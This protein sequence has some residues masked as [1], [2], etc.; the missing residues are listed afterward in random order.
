MPLKTPLP[1]LTETPIIFIVHCLIS[2]G[3]T[4]HILRRKSNVRSAMGWIAL[5]WLTL[6]TGPLLYIVFGINRISR[7]AAR[8]AQIAPTTEGRR[9]VTALLEAPAPIQT[10]ATIAGQITGMPLTAGNRITVYH[11][12]RAAYG[13]MIG[14]IEQAQHSVALA[15]YIFRNDAVGRRFIAAL[16]RAHQRGVAVRVLIDGVGGGFF[17]ARAFRA[18]RAAGVPCARFLHSYAPWR[19]PLLNLRN[20]KK[21][22]ILD[23]TSGFTGGLNIGAENRAPPDAPGSVDDVQVGVTGP[24]IRHLLGTFA[25]DWNFTT[26][27]SLES[28]IWWPDSLQAPGPT[29]ARGIR[30]GPDADLHHIETLLGAAL[31]LAEHRVR[32]VTPY[33]LPDDQ[34]R[35]AIELACMRGVTVEIVI[36]EH[37]DHRLID[38]AVRAHLRASRQLRP[39]VFL[40]ATPFNHAKLM[41]IDGIWS[42]VGSSNWDARSLRLNFEFDLECYDPAVCAELDSLIDEK[43]A[44]SRPIADAELAADPLWKRQRDAAARLLLPYL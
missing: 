29:L 22:L 2:F 10:L 18:L 21:L 13:P 4:W 32:I 23:G 41:T 25:Q 37:S 31:S 35:S 19:M 17:T 5:V 33:F 42:L 16:T 26:N 3:L 39:R 6:I 14:A 9:G 38:W 20:H 24:V 30:S 8:L 40:G 11:G 36:P 27:E 1:T 15:G 44:R 7:K 43:I 28:E 12:G 34:L